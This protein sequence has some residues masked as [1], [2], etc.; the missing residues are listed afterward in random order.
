MAKRWHVKYDREEKKV[1]EDQLPGCK[2]HIE[3]ILTTENDRN[4]LDPGDQTVEKL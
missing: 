3:K 2:N 4:Q 1:L